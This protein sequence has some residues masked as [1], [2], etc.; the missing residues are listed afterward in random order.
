MLA[1]TSIN[2]SGGTRVGVPPPTKIEVAIGMPL[3]IA[4]EISIDN[5]SRYFSM[6]WSRSVKVANAQ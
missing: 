3:A 6:M 1:R 5:D 4:R 2:I